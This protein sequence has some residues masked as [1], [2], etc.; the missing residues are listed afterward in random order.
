LSEYAILTHC[1]PPFSAGHVY[2][3]ENAV[4]SVRW[5]GQDPGDAMGEVVPFKKPKSADKHRGKF[6]CRSGFHKWEIVQEKQFD[7]KQGRLVTLFRCR[8]CGATKTDSK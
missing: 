4:F 1:V 3:I 5:Q 2:F 6:M 8:R 7:V